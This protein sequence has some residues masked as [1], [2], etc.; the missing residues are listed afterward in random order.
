MS[1]NSVIKK[2]GERLG[3][4]Q[5]AAHRLYNEANEAA[6]V[7]VKWHNGKVAEQ[8]AVKGCLKFEKTARALGFDVNWPGLYPVLYKGSDTFHIPD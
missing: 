4:D 5:D 1:T 3:I 7:Q 6:D 2:W 8:Q